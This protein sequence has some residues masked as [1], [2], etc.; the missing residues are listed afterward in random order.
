[1]KYNY[2]VIDLHNIACSHYYI[3]GK[4]NKFKTNIKKYYNE[5]CKRTMFSLR[6]YEK[7]FLSENGKMIILSDNPT[8]K[9]NFRSQ[10]SDDY[11]ATRKKHPD[12]FYKAVEYTKNILLSYD[13]KY[14]QYYISFC[15]ADD[16]T[17]PFIESMNENESC[18]LISSD[19]DWARNIEYQNKK[20]HWF[21][22]KD[23]YTCEKFFEVNKYYPSISSINIYKSIRGD[24]SDN[25]KPAIK[26][27]KEE[28]LIRLIE[29]FKDVHEIIYKINS[30]DYLS[31]TFKKKFKDNERCL[32][33]NSQLV[34]FID[35]DIKT[36]EDNKY[37]G[38]FKK[39]T[40]RAMYKSIGMP[41]YFDRRVE[42]IKS[43]SFFKTDKIPRK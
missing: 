8:S 24:D 7:E 25:I 27:L 36:I 1:M 21:N 5:I 15:E 39:N 28:D 16:I 38:R 34:D 30:I 18:L 19:K 14:I 20:V 43:N 9:E 33:I 22:K 23:I 32:R 6:K 42:T 37:V 11:K 13:E 4:E 2:V 3:I 17:K 40:L 10:I 26:N 29:D 35:L 41:D 31:D 12:F